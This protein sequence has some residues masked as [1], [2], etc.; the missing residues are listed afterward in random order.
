MNMAVLKSAAARPVVLLV[1]DDA[2]L[3]QLIVMRIES[4]G[5]QVIAV[6]SG[7][8]ALASV[9][10]MRPDLVVTDLRMGGM[11]GLALFERLRRISPTLP[12]IILTAHGTI[13]DAVAA[14][15]NGLFGFLTKPFDS[16]A[17]LQLI[18]QA[19]D[20]APTGST[21]PADWQH[22][23]VTRSAAMQDLLD[24]ARRVADSLASVLLMGA[25]GT[26]KEMLAKAIHMASPR[27]DGPFVAINCAAIPEQLLET[28]LFGHVRGAFSGAVQANKGLFQAADRGTL[29]LDEI[30]D[31]PFGL[32]SKLLRALQERSVRPVGAAQP[33]A[34]DVRIL[35][36]TH[37]D[38]VKAIAE[39]RFR[40]DLYYRLNV[41]TLTLPSLS[42]RREDIPLLAAHFLRQLA[43]QNNRPVPHLSPD[44]MEMLVK[45]AWPGNV[46]QLGNVIENA[47][48]VSTTPVIAAATI[49]QA[50][51]E[52]IG[53]AVSFDEARR[54][55][56]YDY[57][58]QL[59]KSTRGNVARAARI[60]QRNRTEFYKLLARHQLGP[61]VFKTDG[62][63]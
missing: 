44:A 38:I 30:G 39:G 6:S 29:F 47:V 42:D 31:M 12:V 54:R 45:S 43:G 19:I 52:D 58:V 55:F 4:V 1:D 14:M 57:L 28:E 20:F 25:S 5:Y 11:D 18:R 21:P 26:G 7:E 13:P 10:A 8:E 50:L 35:S 61:G 15:Q 3:L 23:I 53:E 32:Q 63:Q 9:S 49:A 48:A 51:R 40:E 17:L 36:A 62:D 2:D 46:R 27:R 22:G 41:V 24:R 34:V 33:V 56:E 60:A 59:L 37:R 16:A